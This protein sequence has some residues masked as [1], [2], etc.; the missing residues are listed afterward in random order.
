LDIDPED[1]KLTDGGRILD[2]DI[3]IR[4]EGLVV[5]FDGSYWHNSDA[6][7]D[8]DTTKTESLRRAGWTV[9][10]VREEPLMPTSP[11]DVLMPFRQDMKLTANDVLL[12]IQELLGN[13]I[14][15]IGDYIQSDGLQNTQA[16][17]RF[18]QRLLR[19]KNKVDS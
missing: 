10:R 15:G 8:R 19:E 1:R 12:K 14:E 7:Y 5:E 6:M 9:I 18:V 4:K 11:C 13:S 3:I 2:C 16:S 17:K